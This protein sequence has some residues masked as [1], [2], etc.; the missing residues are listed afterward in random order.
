[1]EIAPELLEANEE[2]REINSGQIE[3]D[4]HI[5]PRI[6][7]KAGQLIGKSSSFGFLGMVTVDTNVTLTG[8]SNP[9]SYDGQIWRL[10]A[11]APFDYFEEPIKTQLY[12]KIPR[13]AEPRGGKIDF[14]INGKL[15]GN[16]FQEGIDRW[17]D[18][19]DDYFGQCGDIECPYSAGHLSL[20]YDFI[21][22]TQIR[23]NIGYDLGIPELGPYG[24]KGNS[25]NPA[26]IGIEDGAIKYELV[27]LKD[28]SLEHGIDTSGGSPIFTVNDE[29][30][31]LAV[32]LVQMLD[33]QTIKVEIFPGKTADEITG[34]TDAA[35]IYRR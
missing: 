12:E 8:Y 13:T 4:K 34:F 20:V 29:S 30:K 31:I 23:I 35:R 22:P 33:D 7:V 21:D 17:F 2:L 26:D 11:V 27:D 14:D 32:F 5:W 6:A 24:V 10:H 9:D 25:P 3:E 28:V 18:S 19:E 15:V 1:M 16:W